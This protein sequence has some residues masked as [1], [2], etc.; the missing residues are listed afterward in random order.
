MNTLVTT[1][2]KVANHPHEKKMKKDE[3]GNPIQTA[4]KLKE[5]WV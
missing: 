4:E 5:I 2:S 1:A 3:N